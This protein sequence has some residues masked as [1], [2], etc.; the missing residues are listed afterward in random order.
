MLKGSRSAVTNA[1]DQIDVIRAENSELQAELRRLAAAPIPLSEAL[2]HFDA[3]AERQASEAISRLHPEHLLDQKY[4]SRGLSLPNVTVRV[5]DQPVEAHRIAIDALFGAL[6]ATNL[7]A[8]RSIV[9]DHLEAALRGREPLSAMER[10]E[11]IAETEARLMEAELQEEGL[12]R[13]LEAAGLDVQRRADASPAAVL[14]HDDS[15]PG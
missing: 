6:I 1:M 11:R 10:A 12:I 4:A 8:L 2:E 14:A 15:L 7:P 9:E 5:G 13:G 3:W